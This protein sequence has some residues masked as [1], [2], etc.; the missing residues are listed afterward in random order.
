M[1]TAVEKPVTFI[2]GLV[3]LG[4]VKRVWLDECNMPRYYRV[5]AETIDG[6]V[7]ATRCLLEPSAKKLLSVWLIYI[8]RGWRVAEE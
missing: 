2:E 7:Y 8:T 5:M 4:R 3:Y 1:P 6:Q